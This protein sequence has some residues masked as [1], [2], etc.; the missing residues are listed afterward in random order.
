VTTV[1]LREPQTMIRTGYGCLF[2]DA[3]LSW[4]SKASDGPALP[5]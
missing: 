4:F 3:R 5:L 2:S 1:S